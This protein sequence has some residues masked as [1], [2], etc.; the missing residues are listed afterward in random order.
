M[1]QTTTK[2]KAK[3]TTAPEPN[4]AQLGEE[5]DRLFEKGLGDLGYTDQ[6]IERCARLIRSEI[7]ST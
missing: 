4:A 1:T 5:V 6:D 7:K 2:Q 3:T